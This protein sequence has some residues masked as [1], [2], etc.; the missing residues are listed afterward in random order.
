MAVR[1]GGEKPSYNHLLKRC[2]VPMMMKKWSRSQRLISKYQFGAVPPATPPPAPS[3][4]AEPRAIMLSF[5]DLQTATRGWRTDCFVAKGR[6]CEVFRGMLKNKQIV[7]IKRLR[8][9]PAMVN[10]FLR[11]YKSE[12][13]FLHQLHHEN[14]IELKGFC[15]EL[16]ELMLVLEFAPKGTLYDRLHDSNELL[17]WENRMRIA[18]GAAR[19]IDYIHHVVPGPVLHRDIKSTHI[20]IDEGYNAKLIDFGNAIYE[21]KETHYNHIVGTEPYTAPEYKR[22]NRLTTKCDIYGFGVVLLEL[23]TGRKAAPEGDMRIMDWATVRLVAT[24]NWPTLVPGMIDERIRETVPPKD[25]VKM[26][27]L[28]TDCIRRDILDRPEASQVVARLL[29]ISCLVRTAPSSSGGGISCLEH[30]IA[31]NSIEGGNTVENSHG[32]VTTDET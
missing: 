17:G 5:R 25:M 26:M 30:T 21:P 12:K 1:E 31:T 14:I 19:A 3:E 23:I 10:R 7:A 9:D 20:V 11:E 13:S 29:E 28:A 16:E 6:T 32:P 24:A 27:K 15:T 18:L 8:K 2:D 22:E 4:P